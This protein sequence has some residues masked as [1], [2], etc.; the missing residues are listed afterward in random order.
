[1]SERFG[2]K[3]RFPVDFSFLQALPV[4]TVLRV[5]DRC[6]SG[7]ALVRSLSVSAM[8]L[9]AV[10]VALALF[11]AS[12]GGTS[13][14]L[15]DIPCDH[16]APAGY[17]CTPLVN[18]GTGVTIG[19]LFYQQ[20]GGTLTMLTNLFT[21]PDTNHTDQKLCADDDPDPWASEESCLGG[22]AETKITDCASLPDAGDGEEAAGLYEVFIEGTGSGEPLEETTEA[23]DSET[24]ARY[25]VC[26]DEYSYFSFHFN[27]GEFSIESF[28]APVSLEVTKSGS[29]LSKVGDDVT[30]QITIENTSGIPLYKE[31]ILDTLL[32]D[33]TDGTNPAIDSSDCGASLAPGSSCTINL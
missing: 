12:P 24:L 23:V 19:E 20:S 4:R 22:S 26:V 29:E 11:I 5:A 33:L 9:A 1:M 15:N 27:Q 21:V 7:F 17:D 30:Y 25:D 13:E 3:R 18:K 10:A 2:S 31:S 32:G 14:A 16:D 8:L 6:Q 28:F